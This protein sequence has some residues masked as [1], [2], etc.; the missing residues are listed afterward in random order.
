MLEK[1][2]YMFR[3][4]SSF[5]FFRIMGWRIEGHYPKEIPK[6]V[7][8]VAPHTSSWDFPIGLMVRSILRD[9]YI[10]FVGKESLFRPPFGGI[11]RWLGGYPVDRSKRTNYVDSIIDIF[12]KEPIFH[13]TLAPEGTRKKVER[14]KTGFYYIAV[15]AKVPIVPIQFDFGTKCVRIA[16]PF[17]PGENAESD[18][19]KLTDYWR[20]IRGFHADQ[21]IS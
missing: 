8:A 2:P 10:R 11:F 17:Y 1:Q 18:L 13:L 21:G 14:I 12:R 4:L 3:L 20:G 9:P 19:E 15:G 6:F 7:I 5:V 16:D